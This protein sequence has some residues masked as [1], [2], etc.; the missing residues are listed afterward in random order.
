MI[1]MNGSGGKIKDIQEAERIAEQTVN[2]GQF[3]ASFY[4]IVSVFQENNTGI[5]TF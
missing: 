1:H 4:H 5:W 2:L 3:T